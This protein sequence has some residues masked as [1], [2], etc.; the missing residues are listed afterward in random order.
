[1]HGLTYLFNV[2]DG[3]NGLT[4]G[5]PGD[6]GEPT[7]VVG[8]VLPHDLHH[9]ISSKTGYNRPDFIK[10]GKSLL[11]HVQMILGKDTIIDIQPPTLME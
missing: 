9:P 5:L 2:L 8:Y 4:L 10:Y 11:A 3:G 6:A 1:M 7:P